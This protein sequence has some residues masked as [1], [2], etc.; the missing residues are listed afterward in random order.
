VTTGSQIFRIGL[1]VA[2]AV[3]IPGWVLLGAAGLFGGQRV[4]AATDPIPPVFTPAHST[5]GE[6]LRHYLGI[7][8][9][10]E[11]PIAF[12]HELHISE[13]GLACDFCHD[14][15]SV[16]PIARIPSIDLC[17]SC[18]LEVATD[19]SEIQLLT[20]YY[21]RS[22]EPPW[23]RVYGWPSEAHVRFNH[24]PHIRAEVGCTTCHGNLA[25]MATAERAVDHTMGFCVACHND[26]QAPTDCLTCHY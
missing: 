1:W 13:A 17:M 6:A 23:Q 19:R 16:G 2:V 10:P 7:R 11:Q 24:A 3:A 9:A 5:V 22:E 25:A 8:S 14:S 4:P 18:H 26:R 20:S 21:D 12:S 15:A